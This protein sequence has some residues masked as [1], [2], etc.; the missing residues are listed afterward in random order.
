LRLDLTIDLGDA[1]LS[2][3][4]FRRGC[5]ITGGHDHRQPGFF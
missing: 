4:R 5:A 1:E 3:N 2:G